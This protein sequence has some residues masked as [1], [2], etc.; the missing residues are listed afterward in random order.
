MLLGH[1]AALLLSPSV[2]L[3]VVLLQDTARYIAPP[4][5]AALLP[6]NDELKTEL[7]VLSKDIAPP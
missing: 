4:F 3:I 2:P 5:R 6:S 7:F 1:C